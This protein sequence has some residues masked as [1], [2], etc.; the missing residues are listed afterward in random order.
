MEG[1]VW[2]EA[3]LDAWIKSSQTMVPGSYMY[4]SQKNVEMRGKIVQYLKANSE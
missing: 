3:K 2:D 1:I 4:Y